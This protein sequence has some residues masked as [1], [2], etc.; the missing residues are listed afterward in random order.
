M[1][2]IDQSHRPQPLFS[3]MEQA[4]SLQLQLPPL[5]SLSPQQHASEERTGIIGQFGMEF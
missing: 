3:I 5:P 4:Y 2:V 1:S